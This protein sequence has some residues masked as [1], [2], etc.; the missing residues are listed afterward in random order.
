[1][2]WLLF[3]A[4][5]IGFIGCKSKPEYPKAE[6]ALDAGREFLDGFL[7]GNSVKSK[8]YMVDDEK[9]ERMLM[10]AH[11]QYNSLSKEAK[12]ELETGSIII[13][14][15]DEVTENEVIIQY[16]SSYD[17]I[18]RKIKVIKKDGNWLVDL[19]YTFNPNM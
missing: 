1:M 2:K 9:N 19:K 17:K 14:E 15:V 10:S 11:R 13:G 7:K 8:A 5:I 12:K 4:L 18:G 16:K 3:L 6:N